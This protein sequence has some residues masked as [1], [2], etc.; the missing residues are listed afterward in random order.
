M[1]PIFLT[2]I[3][4]CLTYLKDRVWI[5]ISC[6]DVWLLSMLDTISEPAAIYLPSIF[7]IPV[8]SKSTENTEGIVQFRKMFDL[9]PMGQECPSKPLIY[10]L[11]CGKTKNQTGNHFCVLV[12]EPTKRTIYRLGRGLSRNHRDNNSQDWESWDGRRIWSR[13]LELMGWQES[14]LHPMTL[15]T[16]DWTQNGYDCGPIACHVAESLLRQGLKIDDSGWCSLPKLLPC[17][18]PLRLKMVEVGHKW[19]CDGVK[20]IIDGSDRTKSLLRHRFGDSEVSSSMADIL[21][22]VHLQTLTSVH[23]NLKEAMRR[24][25]SCRAES[26]RHTGLKPLPKD[27]KCRNDYIIG[28]GENADRDPSVAY[29]TDGKPFR[30]QDLDVGSARKSQLGTVTVGRF[31]R[32]KCLIDLDTMPHIYGHINKFHNDFDDYHGGPTLE[33]LES[34]QEA[35]FLTESSLVYL[36]DQISKSPWNTYR[37]YGFRLLPNFAE[38]FNY[39][40]PV[41]VKEHTCPVGLPMPASSITNY[42]LDQKSREG[43]DVV[44]N[45]RLVVGI[46]DL[47]KMAEAEGDGILLTGKTSDK[48]YICVDLLKDAIKPQ[49]L[50]LSCDL[51]SIIWITNRP[52]FQSPI[53]ILCTPQL[54]EKAPIY[55]NNHVYVELLCPSP[56]AGPFAGERKEWSTVQKPLSNIPNLLAGMMPHIKSTAE[57][58]IFFPRMAHQDPQRH[59]VNRIVKDVQDTFWDCVLLPALHKVIPTS[60]ASYVPSDRFQSNFKQ[61]GGRRS[62][63]SSLFPVPP[64]CFANMVQRME[65]TVSEICNLD[66]VLLTTYYM[67]VKE[68]GDS[69]AQFGSFF[70]VLQIKGCKGDAHAQCD[71]LQDAMRVALDQ[72]Q[73]SFPA[74][75]WEYMKDRG[76]GELLCDVGITV[77]PDGLQPLVGLWRLDCL[78]ASFG[79]GGYK[80][81][82]LHNLNTLSMFGSQ[83]A[84]SPERRYRR[85]HVIFR[86]AYNLSYEA[87]RLYNNSRTLFAEKKVYARNADFLEEMGGVLKIFKQ[88]ASRSYGVRDEF[89]I[90]GAALE[91]FIDGIHEMVNLL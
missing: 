38:I 51:D 64:D 80:V 7:I 4:H 44:V 11:N 59:W 6:I 87:V 34:I 60:R 71:N 76:Q 5:D 27:G 67:K 1:N 62:T 48:K 78:E 45:D 46:G 90:G 2:T 55:K 42:I 37:D 79:A 88:S 28:D 66:D 58:L 36:C 39:S 74:L 50:V 85:T 15:Q 63:A 89:R 13:V 24:C 75:D 30:E 19:I 33:Y 18:H 91:G 65:K 47:L 10:I 16:L 52:R 69:L 20:R 22:E 40:K 35:N 84:E 43:K 73:K 82:N 72:F 86:S 23:N 61:A 83:Q 9:P 41:N 32:P 3:M 31:P 17:C 57:L 77:Q 70:F 68:G 53:G 21:E 56:E 49:N 12:F 54:R 25:S 14:K 29:G 8:E 81:G 26:S